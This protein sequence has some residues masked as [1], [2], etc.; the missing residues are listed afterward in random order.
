MGRLE[1]DLSV[2]GL[3]KQNTFPTMHKPEP[4]F[5]VQI[6]LHYDYSLDTPKVNCTFLSSLR[7]MNK[8]ICVWSCAFFF[9]LDSI[10][11]TNT[12][13]CVRLAEKF[14][15]ALQI[16]LFWILNY[17]LATSHCLATYFCGLKLFN[18]P[19]TLM[20]SSL[21]LPCLFFSWPKFSALIKFLP[22]V[23]MA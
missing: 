5:R 16:K 19:L 21:A 8:F 17:S 18:C 20:S 22:W 12:S 11:S 3:N 4:E 10:N 15:S 1:L 6:F 7:R 2:S 14:S 23:I 13:I 9:F